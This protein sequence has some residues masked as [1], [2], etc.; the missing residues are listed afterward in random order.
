[1][2]KAI[3]IFWRSIV[4][5]LAPANVPVPKQVEHRPTEHRA[6]EDRWAGIR[7]LTPAQLADRFEAMIAE[8]CP[9]RPGIKVKVSMEGQVV[10]TCPNRD[11]PNVLRMRTE[12]YK[13][14]PSSKYGVVEVY[15]E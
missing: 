5:A 13:L 4:Q 1:M 6:S 8:L 11:Y 15:S 2:S 3:G 10:V 9:G 14:Y 12:F 7:D